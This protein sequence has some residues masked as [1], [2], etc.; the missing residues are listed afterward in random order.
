MVENKIVAAKIFEINAAKAEARKHAT[1]TSR[2]EF[3]IWI[4][5]EVD[6]RYDYIFEILKHDII[7]GDLKARAEPRKSKIY[8]IIQDGDYQVVYFKDEGWEIITVLRVLT[9]NN[10]DFEIGF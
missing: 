10:Q 6:D 9:I 2:P 1:I 5:R 4:L 3:F 7:D 8:L